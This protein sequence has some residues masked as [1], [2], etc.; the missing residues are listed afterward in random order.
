MNLS[1]LKEGDVGKL[2]KEVFIVINRVSEDRG[3][4]IT[5]II[6]EDGSQREFIWDFEDPEVT[7]IGKGHLEIV[8]D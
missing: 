5:D 2:N 4:G 1:E 6:Y 3:S 7:L 8:I